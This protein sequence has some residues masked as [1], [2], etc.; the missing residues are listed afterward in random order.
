MMLSLL[1]DLEP[2]DRLRVELSEHVSLAGTVRWRD[3][4]RCGL[5]LWQRI[6]SAAMVQSLYEQQRRGE[7]RPLRLAHGESAILESE[8]GFQ[9][10]QLRDLSQ[11]R[12]KIACDKE[13]RAEFPVKVQLTEEIERRGVV[14]WAGEGAA[15]IFLTE[16][17][18]A[19]DLGSLR[20]I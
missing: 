2:G 5:Q 20:A 16:Q 7:S 12:M 11:T 18:S 19:E 3:G 13:F 4:E 17:L 10:V 9:I 8:D 1:L 15:G 14:R 6:D